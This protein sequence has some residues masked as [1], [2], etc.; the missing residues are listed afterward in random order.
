VRN[1]IA[2]LSKSKPLLAALVAVTALALVG[3]TYAY[4]AFSKSVTLTLDGTAHNASTF[5][6]TV[7]DVLSAEGIVVGEHDLVA[8]GVDEQ[9]SDGSEI[10]VRFGR[11]LELRV[12][13]KATTYW[14]T[15]TE[16]SS[17]LTE[18][19]R[20][21][22]GAELS[23]SRSSSIG[24]AGMALEVVTVKRLKVK[25]GN[26]HF[27]KRRLTALTVA[28]ALTELGIKVHQHDVVRPALDTELVDGRR[29]VLT[30]IRV[31]TKSVTNQPVRFSTVEREDGSMFEGETQVDRAGVKGAR[32]VTYRLTYRNGKLVATKVVEQRILR[33]PVSEIVRVGTKPNP[34]TT[35]FAGGSTVWDAL[36]RCE[37][38]GNW[39]INTGNGYYG[40]LQF[41]LGTW[42]A[43][44]GSGYPNQ[45]S[46]EEQIR[47]A[48]K[49]R[50][51]SG[52]YGA[53]PACASRLGLP[54]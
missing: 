11:P 31:V 41:S 6:D 2:L 36:A 20:A 17:A 24:R 32:D 38:G 7:G 37:S 39:A 50:A 3:T 53:W 51:A 43:Y 13:G 33:K 18:V 30:R 46:R 34:S 45:N 16:V 54:R 8:P 42:R 15:S 29:L 52:G 49:V 47:I 25:V 22:R 12:D 10:S 1:R 44:G 40:G 35:N 23:T 5:G 48:E 14:V 21:F 9:V 27:V 4:Q 26:Q 19:G 28:D